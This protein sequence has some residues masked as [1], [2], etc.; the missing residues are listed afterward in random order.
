ME[1]TPDTSEWLLG[2]E[3]LRDG[4]YGPVFIGLRTTTGELITAERLTLPSD[5]KSQQ[6]LLSR[7][8]HRQ[9][10]PTGSHIVSYQACEEKEGHYYLLREHVHGATLREVIQRHH[11]MPLPLV[12]SITRQIVLGLGELQDQGLVTVFLDLDHV[13][14]SNRGDVKIEAPVLDLTATGHVLPQAL[15]TL[16]EI[17]LG[18]RQGDLR[19]ADV[20]LL[21]VVIVQ[22]IKGMG[23]LAVN[24][25]ITQVQ[26]TDG[27]ASEAFIPPDNRDEATLD[28]LRRCFTM[29]VSPSI[30]SGEPC[31]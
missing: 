21:G 13:L 7:L 23:S 28:F 29:Q 12:R 16:P 5:T 9:A 11:A 27:S 31:S 1:G 4:R 10:I 15:L 19:K 24:E 18:Q 20:W 30:Y 25:I 8:Q 17:A 22:L 2:D 26:N 6:S 14:M 3:K